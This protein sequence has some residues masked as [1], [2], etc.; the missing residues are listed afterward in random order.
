V[1][2]ICSHI[3]VA[4][5]V[6][7]TFGPRLVYSGR[8]DGLLNCVFDFSVVMLGIDLTLVG[9]LV[10]LKFKGVL[11]KNLLI[12]LLKKLKKGFVVFV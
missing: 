6:K 10:I 3:L 11:V 8:K 12:F 4:D 7:E 5:A 2:T 9:Y 1:Q